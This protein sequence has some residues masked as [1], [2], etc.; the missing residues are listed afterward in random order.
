MVVPDHVTVR[1]LGRACLSSCVNGTARKRLSTA[2]Q[3]SDWGG[4]SLTEV[5]YNG[6]YVRPFFTCFDVLIVARKSHHSRRDLSMTRREPPN[7]PT[8]ICFCCWSTSVPIGSFA[9]ATAAGGLDLPL[10]PF[11]VWRC[12]TH[13]WGGGFRPDGDV[14]GSP[15]TH[16]GKQVGEGHERA[17]AFFF[18]GRR[19]CGVERDNL[20]CCRFQRRLL[21]YT[22]DLR[23]PFSFLAFSSLQR[24]VRPCVPVWTFLVWPTG[25]GPWRSWP[26]KSEPRPSRTPRHRIGSGCNGHDL[27][28]LKTCG[29]CFL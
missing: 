11:I 23:S 28:G 9:A 21:H 2:Q 4:I 29:V 25:D 22:P 12:T 3:G 18:A 27:R 26:R 8:T 10:H 24:K 16:G 13:L 20:F 5:C 6:M 7:V 1:T 15:S 17:F 19:D 14:A